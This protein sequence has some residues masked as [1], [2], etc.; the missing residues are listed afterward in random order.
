MNCRCAKLGQFCRNCN[1]LNHNRCQNWEARGKYQL[2]RPKTAGTTSSKISPTKPCMS[3]DDH[4]APTIMDSPV[5]QHSGHDKPLSYASVVARSSSPGGK[6]LSSSSLES[7]VLT[8]ATRM[9][10]SDAVQLHPPCSSLS[11]RQL[12]CSKLSQ[13]QTLE[14]SRVHPKLQQQT[15]S[16]VAHIVDMISN[17]QED[18]DIHDLNQTASPSLEL[19]ERLPYRVMASPNFSWGSLNGVEVMSQIEQAYQEVV[20]WRRN[21]F[22]VPYGSTGKMFASELA[23]L[24]H[25]YA[26]ASALECV[27]LTAAMV[28][29]HLLLQ[30][31]HKRSRGPDHVSCLTRRLEAWKAGD[32]KALL[33]EAKTI[34]QHLTYS[35]SSNKATKIDDLPH[36]FAGHLKKGNVNAAMRLLSDEGANGLLHLD[37]Y[38][39]NSS[40]K[41]VRDVLKEKHP[42]A[43]SLDPDYVVNSKENAS[44][45]HPVLFDSL[46]GQ[47]IRNTAMRCSGAAGPSG[48]DSTQWKRLC[49][50]FHTSSKDLC[51]ALAAV[52]RRISTE[53]VDPDGI[54]ALVACRLVPLNKNPGV[55]PIGVCETVRRIIGKAVLSVVKS[56]VLS[57][58]GTLQLC[59]GQIAG[60]E[61]AIHAMQ[62]LFEDDNTEA[63]LLVDATNAF[64]SLNRQLALKNISSTCPAIHT[65][66]LNTYQQPSPLFVGGE[67]LLSREG[68]TQGDP[69]AMAMYALA[70]VPLLK[71]VQTEGSTQVWYADDAAA[72]GKIQAVKQWWEKLSIHGEKFGYFPNAKKS[73][74]IVKPNCLE[75]AKRVFSKTAVNI[76][77]E[78]RKYLGAALGTENF[79]NGYL[80]DAILDWTRQIDKLASIAQSQ[81]QAAHSALSHGL[82]GRWIFTARTNQNFKTFAGLL[83]SSIQSQLIPAI[84]GRSAPGELERKLFSLPARLGGLGITDPTSLS[85]EYLN[86]RK[87]TAPLVDFILNQE[88]TLGDA[89][90]QQ[91]SLKKQI[92]KHKGLEIKTLADNVRDNLSHQ[93]KRMFE[94]ANEKGASNWL[95]V[96]PLEDHGFSL[97]KSA[98]R[99][100][101]CLRYGWV[102][103]HMSESCPCGG[104]M[105]VE[106]AMSCPT[107]G[108]PTI[109]HNEIRD[110]FS[111]LLSDVCHDVET[112]PT[113][114]SLSGETFSLRSSSR[115]DDA[116]LDISARGFWG[117]RFEKTYFDVRVF[118]PNATSYTCFEVASCYRRQEQE[119][120]RKY[121]ERLRKV[122]NASFTPIILSCT[123]GMSKLTTSFT[124]KLASMISEKKDTPY[125]SVINWLRCRL[126]FALLRASIMCIRGSR[127]KRYVRP[128]NNILLA[129]SEGHLA[130][131]A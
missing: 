43:S 99:D 12:P 59:A 131:S 49:T 5:N 60:C 31:P 68:T 64:N 3:S 18:E 112:E 6:A 116:R 83:E 79:C 102:P 30:K 61:A 58:T 130:S 92:R 38:L 41:T 122:E 75:E 120:K 21:L 17:T 4:Q 9:L 66:L 94:L 111:H 89:P 48:L 86:S 105:S 37:D 90:D 55:R 39:T 98:F 73:W 54:S 16:P 127:C 125:G 26:S 100:A 27:S 23:R 109:R 69:L 70:T 1:P 67:V 107:G 8:A 33:Y 104:K 22:Q 87:M 103:P 76:T 42:N 121:E 78:G 2:Q 62:S 36:V 15:S 129:T 14:Q 20:H 52:A 77:S 124:K 51:N 63:I 113:L 85:S 114:Q 28:M 106:H 35:R 11:Q 29:P 7:S 84:T 57:A 44:P 88:I 80:S 108:F 53:I 46:D 93:H 34:Q 74:L 45:V 50:G 24:F 119:K 47:L 91:D 110:T 72:G 96:L 71:K 128:E 82:L 81:P 118:N 115:D 65:V 95:T 101:L 126:G 25:A 97:H 10:Y 40:Q 117:G 19:H 123:G 13:K 56:D 32:I